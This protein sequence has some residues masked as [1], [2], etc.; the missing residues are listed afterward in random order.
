MTVTMTTAAANSI[1]RGAMVPIGH[2]SA[3]NG[4]VISFTSI[5]NTYKDLLVVIN[6]VAS[7]TYTG[8]RIWPRINGDTGSNYS[9]T[10]LKGDGTSPSS[11]RGA[12]N[13][14]F[15]A[16]DDFFGNQNPGSMIMHFFNYADTARFKH[17][18]IRTA[19]DANG[20]GV[21]HLHAITWRQTAAISDIG[22]LVAGGSSQAAHYKASIYGIR[23]PGQ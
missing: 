15:W 23:G 17:G 13:G 10:T 12:N 5:P 18:L 22:L 6:A 1:M 21:V 11:F 2:A 20:S 4:N 3:I 7:S 19:G 16:L 9:Y 14:S 8:S